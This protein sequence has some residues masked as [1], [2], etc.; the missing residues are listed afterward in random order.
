MS[1]FIHFTV[2]GL[3]MGKERSRARVL[4]GGKIREYTPAKTG[5][6]EARVMEA[7]RQ[8]VGPFRYEDDEPIVI[9]IIAYYQI[10][11]SATKRKKEQMLSGD[12]VPICRPDDDNIWKIIA[13]ALNHGVAYKDDSRIVTGYVTKRYSDRPRVSVYLWRWEKDGEIKWPE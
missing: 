2:S 8:Q 13:D 11:S 6:Y 7:Y 9:C 5:A 10:P 1:S 3:P 4:P 12:I